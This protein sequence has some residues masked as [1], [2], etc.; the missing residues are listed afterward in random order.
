MLWPVLDY[1][2]TFFAAVKCTRQ[3]ETDIRSRNNSHIFV[4]SRRKIYIFCVVASNTSPVPFS[5][6]DLN[7]GLCSQARPGGNTEPDAANVYVDEFSFM[8]R[9]TTENC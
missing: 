7:T 5:L 2:E 1:R 6:R 9:Y 4:L 3:K 8:H